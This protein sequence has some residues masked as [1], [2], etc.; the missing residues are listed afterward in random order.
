MRPAERFAR[1]VVD[2]ADLVF[3][4][5][6]VLVV[7][8]ADDF[9]EHVFDRHQP[10][11]AAVFVEHDGDVRAALLEQLQQVVDRLG[12]GHEQRLAQ[13]FGAAAAA[14]RPAPLA[15]SGSRSLL[16]RM[17]T[18]SSRVL[19]YTGTRVWPE[20]MTL[21]TTSSHGVSSWTCESRSAAS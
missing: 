13:Q 11:D 14:A 6:I 7:D 2:L 5:L 8:L 12:F 15:S 3:G 1:V 9:L 17:P 19:S 16:Y 4:L 10:G 21:S 20:S 18:M